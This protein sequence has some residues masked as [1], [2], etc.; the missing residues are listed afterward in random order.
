MH[1]QQLLINCSSSPSNRFSRPSSMLNSRHVYASL[2]PFVAEKCR[3]TP[4]RHP[5]IWYRRAVNKEVSGPIQA[6]YWPLPIRCLRPLTD[7]LQPKASSSSIFYIGG[8]TGLVSSR[9]SSLL[10]IINTFMYSTPFHSK[11]TTID[12]LSN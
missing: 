7:I 6:F 2:L 8:G 3:D 4:R 12:T 10:K 5:I 1:F 11:N 9:S